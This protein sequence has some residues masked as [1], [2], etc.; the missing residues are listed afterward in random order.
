MFLA[1]ISSLNCTFQYGFCEWQLMNDSA[2]NWQ[3]H[4]GSTP[5][6]N[7]GPA[8][9]HTYRNSLGWVFFYIKIDFI[10]KLSLT[11]I[12]NVSALLFVAFLVTP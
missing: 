5:S 4:R 1:D 3:R 10:P 8:Y 9:D 7:T 2:Y 12:K 11:L 6:F